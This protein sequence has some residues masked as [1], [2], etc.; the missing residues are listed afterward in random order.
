MY[1]YLIKEMSEDVAINKGQKGYF[2]EGVFLQ[3]QKKNKNK[4]IYSKPVLSEAVDKYI[5]E[6]VDSSRAMGELGHPEE[7]SINLERVSHVV[8][9]LKFEGTDVIGKAKV[10]DTPYGKIAQNLIDEGVKFGVS[11]RG[12]GD[13][14]D[15]G[16]HFEVKK[17]FIIKAIDI[18]ADPSAPD[19][20]VEG[21]MESA[22]WVH[23]YNP[24][25]AEEVRRKV[26]QTSSRKLDEVFI[27][28]FADFMNGL[29]EGKR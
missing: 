20:F 10:I 17:G 13:L 5:G 2:I 22:D 26:R 4:R 25:K 8:K 29:N 23:N 18:V 19:A 9:K 27:E 16:S 3:S 11:S 1:K 12:L 7:S 6:Y 15:A 14:K 24:K 28:L 21:I